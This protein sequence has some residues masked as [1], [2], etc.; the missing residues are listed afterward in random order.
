MVSLKD[1]PEGFSAAINLSKSSRREQAPLKLL[2]GFKYTAIEVG[3]KTLKI[4]EIIT[5]KR[6]VK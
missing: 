5:K 6:R 2:T 1:F 4:I 3:I